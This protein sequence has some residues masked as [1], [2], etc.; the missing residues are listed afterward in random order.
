MAEIVINGLIEGGK[1]TGGPPF[2]PALGPL[3]VN[4]TSIINEINAKTKAFEGMKIAVKVSV[5]PLTKSFTVEVGSPSTSAL[6]LK[7]LGIAKGAKTKDE[8]AGN[9]TIEQVKKI[10]K[11][12]EASLYGNSVADRVK[13]VLGTCKSMNITCEGVSAV[14]M[15]KKIDSGEVKL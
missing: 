15:I 2:G 5:D 6:I 7:E 13:Q 3:G 10:A 8:V 1:A 9:I 14:E 12:K 11:Q 4:V